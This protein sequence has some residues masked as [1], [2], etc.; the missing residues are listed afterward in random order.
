MTLLLI[1]PRPLSPHL[2]S[3]LPLF[4]VTVSE[5]LVAASSA[6]PI[7]LRTRPFLLILKPLLPAQLTVSVYIFARS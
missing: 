5:G 2:N 3:Y 6:G 4:Q 1:M 7:S